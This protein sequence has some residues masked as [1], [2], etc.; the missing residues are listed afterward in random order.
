[1]C[2]QKN[3]I[4]IMVKNVVDVVLG[5]FTYWLFG[6]GLSFG[7]GPYT[8]QFYAVGNFLL[9]ASPER[10]GTEFTTF[11]FQLSF[12]TTAT[13]IVSGAMAERCNF[14]AYCIYSLL[15]TLVY[16]I[17][18]GWL[19]GE[20]GFLKKMGAV[21][22]AG[23]G[24][25][26]LVGG[27]SALVSAAMLKPRKGR[28]DHGTASAPVGD[29]VTA[30]LGL[31]IL[32]WGWLSFNCGSVFGITRYKWKYVGR[33]AVVTICGSFG[34]G[35]IGMFLSYFQ[36][37]KIFDISY[38]INGVLAAL[39]SITAGCALYHPWEAIIIGGI[40]AILALAAIPL[41]DY[42]HVDDPVGAVAVH[43]LGGLWGLL[44][45]GLFSDNDQG[46]EN[47]TNNRAGLFKRGGF[48]FFGI[49]LLA[50]VCLATWSA[51]CSFLLLFFINLIV[52][53]RMS[54]EE[55]LLGADYLEHG[56][57]RDPEILKLAKEIEE[58]KKWKKRMQN[59]EFIQ[60]LKKKKRL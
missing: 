45:V 10:W 56:V 39:V 55:E 46:W 15:N 21:D 38:L 29:P 57:M 28:Y 13:T 50:A 6:Y 11:F 60:F 35:F 2:F 48:Y 26:H 20:H 8:T 31:F 58:R 19:W 33:A 16:C 37:N 42:M 52:P 25:I 32:W 24:G 40:G 4:N 41:V 22:I 1:M 54:E 53:I 59:K 47:L 3:E 51:L 7:K 27:V 36:K 14:I 44:S 34:G 30:I 5:G 17:P 9:D 43:G 49:Q 23:S 12:A 18:A